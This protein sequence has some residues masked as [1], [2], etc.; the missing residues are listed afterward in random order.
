[1]NNQEKGYI[2]L[3]LSFLFM[4]V[5]EIR[6]Y[7][8]GFIFKFFSNLVNVNYGIYYLPENILYYVSILFGLVGYTY[9]YGDPEKDFYKYVLLPFLIFITLNNLPS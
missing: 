7:L 6:L 9:I 4:I 3:S 8:D 2:Y 5:T 1:M